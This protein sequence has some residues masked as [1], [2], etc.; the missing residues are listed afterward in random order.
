V[1]DYL[2]LPV[3]Q[4]GT[5]PE[6]RPLYRWVRQLVHETWSARGRLTTDS[7][8]RLQ[9]RGFYGDYALRYSLGRQATDGVSFAVDRQQSMPLRVEAPFG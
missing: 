3:A 8:G 5:E 1:R 6:V 2:G 4:G 9:F 7:D